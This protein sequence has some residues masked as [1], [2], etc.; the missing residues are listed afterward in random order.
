MQTNYYFLLQQSELVFVI[1]YKY[2]VTH[3]P[4]H[5]RIKA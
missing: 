1:R 3:S 2:N 4:K 5:H